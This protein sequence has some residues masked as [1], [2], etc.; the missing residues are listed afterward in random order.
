MC[1]LSIEEQ[2]ALRSLTEASVET[3]ELAAQLHKAVLKAEAAQ[4]I[5]VIR[6]PSSTPPTGMALA[7]CR[8]AA[9]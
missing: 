7:I 5:K 6:L 8:K 4:P 9:G 3:A 1:C 2:E